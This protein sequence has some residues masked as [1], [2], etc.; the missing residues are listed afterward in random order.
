VWRVKIY[1]AALGSRG[2]NEPFRAFAFEAASAG[3]DV[4]FAH[5][6][7]IPFEDNPPYAELPLNGSFHSFIDEYGMSL[8]SALK[9]YQNSMKPMLEG[10]WA[11]TTDQIRTLTP[12]VVVYHPKLI[13]AAAAAHSVGAI[14]VIVEMVPTLTPTQEFAAAG[15]PLGLPSW[16]NKASFRLVRAGISAMGNPAKKLAKELGVIRTEWDLALCPVSPTLVPQPSDWPQFAHITG[17]WSLRP[18]DMADAEVDTFLN[19]G[20]TLY[21]GFG[22]MKDEGGA[23][24]AT[25]IVDAA[26]SLGLQSLLVTGWGGLVPSAEHLAAP[27]VLVRESVSHHSVLPRIAVALHHGGAGT[28]HAMIREGV[29]SVIMPFVADQPWW[30]KRLHDRGLGGPALSRK[31]TD[32]ARIAQA[33]GQATTCGPAVREAAASMALEDGLAVALQIIEAAESGFETLRPA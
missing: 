3:H 23:A 12:D 28:T 11:L 19:S 24:R 4:F 14:A 2:D 30:A 25:A 33:I 22:S 20:A 29:P 9:G 10:A 7:D 15:L 31:T 16:L 1:V 13:T 17:Q 21:A 5:T 27:D 18:S 8:A 26:R 6:S 32:S